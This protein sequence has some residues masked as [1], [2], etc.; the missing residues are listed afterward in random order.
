MWYNILYNII[1]YNPSCATLSYHPTFQV[2]KKTYSISRHNGNI[3]I[4]SAGRLIHIDFGFVFGLGK[5]L[6]ILLMAIGSG[7]KQR[8]R[9]RRIEDCSWKIR[10]II[11]RVGVKEEESILKTYSRME[12]WMRIFLPWDLRSLFF[13]F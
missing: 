11:V 9:N 12:Y 8:N 4:D 5:K 13:P 2:N 6:K 7:W 1:L 10:E 3:M